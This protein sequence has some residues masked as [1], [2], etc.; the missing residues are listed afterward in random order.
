[1]VNPGRRYGSVDDNAEINQ[2]ELVSIIGTGDHNK[3]E[4][5][6]LQVRSKM[7]K[8]WKLGVVIFICSGA[9]LSYEHYTKRKYSMS[10]PLLSEAE[11][12]APKGSL[13]RTEEVALYKD[14]LFTPPPFST[15]D[16]VADLKVYDYDYRPQASFPGEVFGPLHQGQKKTGVPLPT[17]KW[18]ENMVLVLDGQDPSADHVVYTV[19]FVVNAIGPIPGIKLHATRLLAMEKIVQVTFI[20]RHGVT[21]GSA[22]PLDLSEKS[23]KEQDA[24]AN[25]RYLVDYEV[26]EFSEGAK[27][28][29]LTPLGFTLQWDSSTTVM[30]QSDASSFTKMT[31][32]VVRGMPYGTMHYH[33]KDGEIDTTL[34][35]VV[36]HISLA[37]PPVADSTSKLICKSNI[38]AGIETLVQKSVEISFRESD[39]T[40]VVFYSQPVYVR[41]YEVPGETPFV[42][43]ATHLADAQEGDDEVVFTSRVAL[44]NNCT[45]GTNPSH[46]VLGHPSD[47]AEWA[48]LLQDHADVYPGKHTKI[49]YTFFSDEPNDSAEHSYLQ[50]DWDAR[51]T[52]DRKPEK[53]K[54]VLMY[55]LVSHSLLYVCLVSLLRSIIKKLELTFH[56]IPYIILAPP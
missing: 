29:P 21:L 52:F 33:Y 4:N 25:K 8:F 11:V 56:D 17:N 3:T 37:E 27:M 30:D 5:I 49:D 15:L 35:T 22:K 23:L 34:P 36:S 24:G 51:R 10:P 54:G 46:C 7:K 42:L 13:L 20:D 6:K 55:S 2:A 44:V 38:N 45:R 43:Q 40:W 50:F 41:C 47:K 39:F 26:G 18:Y 32:S 48:N 28:S 16:P 53:D 12:A 31:S 9:A 19:P 14:H 1:M